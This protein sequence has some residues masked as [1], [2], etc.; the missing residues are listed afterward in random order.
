M[1][2]TRHANKFAF[3]FFSKA[4]NAEIKS[5]VVN[6]VDFLDD[7]CAEDLNNSFASNNNTR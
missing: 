3:L 6:D 7:H 4:C 2:C 5:S 1:S